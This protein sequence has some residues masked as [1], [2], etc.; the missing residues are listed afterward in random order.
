MAKLTGKAKTAFLNR[1]NKGR[2]KKG[3]KLIR[4]KKNPKRRT[5]LPKTRKTSKKQ[6]KSV[7]KT[8]KKVRNPNKRKST[9]RSN[10]MAK[11][12][13]GTRRGKFG[14]NKIKK[15]AIGGAVGVATTAVA[16]RLGAR[17]IS[18][19]LGYV[20]A[21]ITGG[22]TPGVVGNAVIR[23]GLTRFGGSLNILNGGSN[24]NGNG[25]TQNTGFA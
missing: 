7:R 11:K 13:N 22:G 16:N 4:I 5:T 12:K 1:L 18:D 17:S 23:Q 6:L 14:G 21:S 8:P 19:D 3:L 25:Q 9:S 10:N 15:G 2:K 24:G 20:L